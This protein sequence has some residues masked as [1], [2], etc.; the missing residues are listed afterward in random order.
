[1][2]RSGSHKGSSLDDSAVNPLLPPKSGSPK[3]ILRE[4]LSK[5]PAS[6]TNWLELP[7]GPKR[8][9]NLPSKAQKMKN[10]LFIMDI[11]FHS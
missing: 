8:M 5:L 10:I 1:M 2:R 3:E 6:A 9:A 4:N 7:F 11:V